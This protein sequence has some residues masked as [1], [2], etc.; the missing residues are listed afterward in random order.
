MKKI[1]AV[2]ILAAMLLATTAW[3]ATLTEFRWTAPTTYMDGGT[4]ITE[5]LTY[6]VYCGTASASYTI[7]T[8]GITTTTSAISSTITSTR[9]NGKY[10]CVVTAYSAAFSAESPASNEVSLYKAGSSF[11]STATT[12]S[13]PVNLQVN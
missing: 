11:L 1:F 12:P 5:P 4:P 8:S 9:P 10:Y 2:S 6:R 3:A 7:V 13:A